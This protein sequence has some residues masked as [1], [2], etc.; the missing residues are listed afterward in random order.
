MPIVVHSSYIAPCLLANG[1]LQTLLPALLR[2][3]TGV[4]YQRE[5]IATPDGDFLDLDWVV[6]GS[7]RLAVIAHGLEGSSQRA[8]VRGMV[9]ALASKGWDAVVWNARGCSGEPNRGLR[10]THSGATEDLHTVIAHLTNSRACDE[11]ALIGFSLGGNVTLK[12]LGERSRDL[13]PWIRK[14]VTFSVPC[15]LRS[16]SLQLASLTNQIYMRHFLVSL[17]Q[18]IRAKMKSMPGK[19]HDRDYRR[20]RTF[21]DFDDRYTAPIHGF[22][23]AEDYWRQCSCRP[24]LKNISIPT[25]LIN[26]RND[27]FLAEACYPIAEAEAN[28]NLHLEMPAS[29]GHVGFITFNQ[30]GEYWSESRALAFLK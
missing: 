20:L 22:A 5:R 8:Y 18:K 7:P 26:A 30:Q 2:K 24:T 21:K 3:V 19:I 6:K 28:P 23:D 9:K 4:A 25:L 17:R 29:G 13:H 27:P 10:F 1:H 12:Y 15:D 11:L 16:G 14:A